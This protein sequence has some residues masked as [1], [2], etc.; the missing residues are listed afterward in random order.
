M[1]SSQASVPP[2][3]WGS[4]SLTIHRS[5]DNVKIFLVFLAIFYV[6]LQEYSSGHITRRNNLFP[7]CVQIHEATGWPQ[8]RVLLQVVLPRPPPDVIGDGYVVRAHRR[9]PQLRHVLLR[10]RPGSVARRGVLQESIQ[11]VNY[12]VKNVYPLQM[13]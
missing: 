5:G 4:N 11:T 1:F 7:R 13:R 6:N 9:R 10:L 2:L 8:L 3:S 12:E